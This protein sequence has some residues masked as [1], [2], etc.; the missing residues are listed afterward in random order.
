[1]GIIIYSAIMRF[2]LLPALVGLLQAE[3][4]VKQ[5]HIQEHGTEYT[6]TITLDY[7][8]NI[9]TLEVPAHNNIVHSKTIF[10]FNQ[11]VLFESHPE[12]NTCYMKDIPAGVLSMERFAAF[13]D[14]KTEAVVAEKQ[15]TKRRAYKTTTLVTPHQLSSMAQEVVAECGKS[16]VFQVEPVPEEE[17]EISYRKAPK[18]LAEVFS[19]GCQMAESCLWQ[20][21]Q[22]GSD[23]CW[24]TVNCDVDEHDCDETLEHSSVIHE[25]ANGHAGDCQ[26]S[27]RPCYNMQCPGCAA[28][29]EGCR[30]TFDSQGVGQCPEN[31][32]L[33]KNCGRIYCPMHPDVAGAA[34][35]CPGAGDAPAKVEE[36]QTCVLWC[37]DHQFGGMITCTHDATWDEG[38]LI[39]CH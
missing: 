29:W 31:P 32:E 7:E 19:M 23:S 39:G 10:D 17:L 9:Q 34:W 15:V 14:K 18:S 11:G 1:M 12:S 35:E 38:S 8:R 26:V 4:V 33:G 13:L 28:S 6:Q 2:L 25:C 21:C 22:V 20:T 24:W 27:C 3:V 30:P 36:G 5:L 37:P 16:T